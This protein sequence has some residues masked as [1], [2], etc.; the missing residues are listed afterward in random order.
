[1][2]QIIYHIS[3]IILMQTLNLFSHNSMDQLTSDVFFVGVDHC[4]VSNLIAL[5]L[6]CNLFSLQKYENIDDKK[7]SFHM[8][9]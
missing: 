9:L 5:V 6:L 2:E 8:D 3:H 1:M 7:E 4:C